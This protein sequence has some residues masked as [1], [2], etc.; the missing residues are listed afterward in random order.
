MRSERIASRRGQSPSPLTNPATP[1][2]PLPRLLPATLRARSLTAAQWLS[3]VCL[4]LLHCCAQSSLA[5]VQPEALPANL[6]LRPLSVASSTC[7][8]GSPALYYADIRP[9]S[10]DVGGGLPGRRRLLRPPLLHSA[11]AKPRGRRLL[12]RCRWYPPQYNA[13]RQRGQRPL[14]HVIA[15]RTGRHRGPH[16]PQRLPC[17][18]PPLRIR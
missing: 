7:N 14:P 9:S 15:R 3:C 18:E 8:D 1:T 17:G 2:S 10:S 6:L 5:V 13:Q 12:C 11:L 16:P 4:L